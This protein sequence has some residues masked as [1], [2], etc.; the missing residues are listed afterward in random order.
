MAPVVPWQ[1]RIES[2]RY[3]ARQVL[4]NEK[5]T[6]REDPAEDPGQEEHEKEHGT[7]FP[8]RPRILTIPSMNGVFAHNGAMPRARR[9]RRLA[10]R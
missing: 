1:E 6:R 8:L 4:D 9:R 3:L 7:V 10:S 5:A 2:P